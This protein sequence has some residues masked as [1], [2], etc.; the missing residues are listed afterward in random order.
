MNLTTRHPM[1]VNSLKTTSANLLAALQE[2]GGSTKSFGYTV[3]EHVCRIF[4]F[5]PSGIVAMFHLISENFDLLV[6]YQQIKCFATALIF[7]IM[8]IVYTILVLLFAFP[9]AKRKL[10]FLFSRKLKPYPRWYYFQ[11]SESCSVSTKHLAV[12]SA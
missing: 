6:T 4:Y 5:N 11:V 7:W 10:C 3:G 1:V 12:L 2:V 9:F 8:S